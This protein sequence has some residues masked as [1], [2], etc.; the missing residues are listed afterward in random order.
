ME[1]SLNI[2]PSI[3]GGSAHYYRTSS[4]GCILAGSNVCVRDLGNN[5]ED[6]MSVFAGHN[7]VRASVVCVGVWVFECA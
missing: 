7:S 6:D 5:C 3:A 4:G 2:R 1:I